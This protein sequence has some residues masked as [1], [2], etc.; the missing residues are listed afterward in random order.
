[1]KTYQ[2]FITELNKFELALK[3]GKVGLKTLKKIGLK[4][5]TK[6]VPVKDII[7]FR[8]SPSSKIVSPRRKIENIVRGTKTPEARPGGKLDTAKRQT[9]F[10][11]KNKA[12]AN[13]FDRLTPNIMRNNEILRAKGL[14][15]KPLRRGL[16]D[17]P[18]YLDASKQ[19]NQ[20]ASVHKNF[21][22]TFSDQY[23]RNKFG[24]LST[25][26][27]KYD[28]VPDS[29]ENKIRGAIRQRRKK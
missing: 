13:Y 29:I 27:V 8:N 7:K 6:K 12:D 14:K 28:K 3:A 9:Q 20:P 22:A 17:H 11:G 25:K 16:G 2:E 18:G 1:M 23:P 15:E 19:L 26:S 4:S 24:N 5:A 21:K 10:R